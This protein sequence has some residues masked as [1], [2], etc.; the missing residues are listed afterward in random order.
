MDWAIQTP[1]AR[2]AGNDSDQKIYADDV[3]LT[4]RRRSLVWEDKLHVYTV[5]G[6][7]RS[8]DGSLH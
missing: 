3:I 4:S 8:V 5:D 1:D 6:T 2:T 7:V